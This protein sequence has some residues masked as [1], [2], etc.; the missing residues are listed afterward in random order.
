M[1]HWQELFGSELYGF[2]YARFV[3]DQRGATEQ[4]LAYCGLP[5]NEACMAFHTATSVVRTASVW[6]VR[7]PLYRSSLGRGQHYAQQLAPLRALL[8]ATA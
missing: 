5:W 2:D 7:K 1:A 3:T 8:A 4:L 6:Q